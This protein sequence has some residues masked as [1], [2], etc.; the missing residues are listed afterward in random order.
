MLWG[1][2]G[3]VGILSIAAIW[4]ET[5]S[6]MSSGGGWVSMWTWQ[7]Q[8]NDILPVR[9]LIS[10]PEAARI[11]YE[12]TRGTMTGY[13]AERM[14]DRPDVLGYY[15]H[16]LTGMDGVT[17]YGTH[18]PSTRREPVPASELSSGVFI[19]GGSAFRRHGQK[20][21]EFANL[22]IK[23]ADLRRYIRHAKASDIDG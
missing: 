8:F 21:A 2:V 22:Q 23:R 6:Q 16:A 17:L 12:R 5:K 18:P 11:A 15:F 4:V 10:L 14:M 20:H 19:D 1:G 3:G 9:R 7:F 13:V